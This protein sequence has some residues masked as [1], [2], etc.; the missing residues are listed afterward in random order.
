M[1]QCGWCFRIICVLSMEKKNPLNRKMWRARLFLQRASRAAVVFKEGGRDCFQRPQP[2][3]GSHHSD[4]KTQAV[5]T[6]QRFIM[7][8]KK[9]KE[10]LEISAGLRWIVPTFQSDSQFF[11]K[12]SFGKKL[13][14]ALMPLWHPGGWRMEGPK[15]PDMVQ[16][17]M[18]DCAFYSQRFAFVVSGFYCGVLLLFCCPTQKSEF[19][20]DQSADNETK[21][22]WL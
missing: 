1:K 4:N 7:G 17:W 19:T 20:S 10:S 22:R 15:G 12:G 6:K 13:L 11:F 9:K 18:S 21:P 2:G 14:E 5:E 16:R 8:G 3:T